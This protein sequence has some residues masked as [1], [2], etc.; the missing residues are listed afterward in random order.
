MIDFSFFS[1]IPGGKYY[2]GVQIVTGKQL[3]AG[4]TGDSYVILVGDKGKTE[5]LSLRGWFDYQVG[6]NSLSNLTIVTDD[7]LGKCWLWLSVVTLVG[8]KITGM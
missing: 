8:L 1:P 6:E 4:T 2:Y 5:K 3:D 7:D